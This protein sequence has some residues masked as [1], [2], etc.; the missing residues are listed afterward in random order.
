MIT[1]FTTAKPFRGHEA[2]IQRNALQ[3]W[4]LSSKGYYEYAHTNLNAIM[5]N[6]EFWFKPVT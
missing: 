6:N 4:K 5:V 1:F 2:I 3:S